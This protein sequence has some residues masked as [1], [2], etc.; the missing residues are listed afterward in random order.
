[1]TPREHSVDLYNR[2][3]PLI[4]EDPRMA[5][6]MLISAVMTDPGFAAGW[7]LLGASLA[8]LG[9]L[10]A[11]CEA[12]R[13][14][15][16]LPDG[17]NVGD[18]DPVLR[19]RCLLQLG[20]RLTNNLIVNDERLDQAEIALKEALALGGD[21]AVDAFCHTNLSLIA[22]HRGDREREMA[23]AERGFALNPDPATELGLA[24]ACLFQGELARGI[25]HF[26]ARYPHQLGSYLSLPWPRWNG[27]EL[28][29][30]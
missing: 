17:P 20:H 9:S 6:Q 26:E 4:R 29:H 7:A 28:R 19:Q 1:M 13:S 8:D 5:Y 30:E 21:P 18:M 10:V 14:A 15:L 3:Q 25:R 22:A 2:A 16:R 12:Y 27:E 24:F 23:H 11:S